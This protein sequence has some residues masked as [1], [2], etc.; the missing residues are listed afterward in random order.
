MGLGLAVGNPP[1]IAAAETSDTGPAPV[2][3]D[4]ETT[5]TPTGDSDDTNPPSA[6]DSDDTTASSSRSSTTERRRPFSIVRSSGGARTAVRTNPNKPSPPIDDDSSSAVRSSGGGNT[7]IRDWRRDLLT[8]I[9]FRGDSDDV[10]TEAPKPP[11]GGSRG[12]TT[13]AATPK[14]LSPKKRK[15]VEDTTI[16]TVISPRIDVSAGSNTV[17]TDAA[18]RSATP[19]GPIPTTRT[20][21]NTTTSHVAPATPRISAASATPMRASVRAVAGVLGLVGVAPSATG[22]SVPPPEHPGLWALLAWTR[23][24]F[25]RT[26]RPSAI[27]APPVPTLVSQTVDLTRPPVDLKAAELQAVQAVSASP[28]QQPGPL[29]WLRDQIAQTLFNQPPTVTVDSTQTS[30]DL[31]GVTTGLLQATDPEGDP[32]TYTVTRQPDNGT[33]VV[34]AD[35]TF[36]YTPDAGFAGPD[37]FTVRATDDTGSVVHR[38]LRAVFPGLHSDS[39][40]VQVVAATADTIDVGGQP[41]GVV[42][43]PDGT[44]TY[45]AG[46]GND[47]VVVID[48]ATN[49]VI[50]RV[51]VGDG[52]APRG[53]AV[54]PDGT[55]VYVANLGTSH[56]SII[57]TDTNTVIDTIDVGDPASAIALSPNGDRV[58]VTE[59]AGS[60]AGTLTVIDTGTKDTIASVPVGDEPSDV[61]VSPSGDQVYVT[62][63]FSDSVSLY[64]PG[65]T[66]VI[67]IDAGKS[68]IGIALSDDGRR[69]YIVNDYDNTV[70][71][72]D[73]TDSHTVTTIDV[74][75]EPFGIA[76]NGDR[77]YVTNASGN[78]VTVIDTSTNSVVSTIAVDG[79][80]PLDLALSPDGSR[81]YVTNYDSGTVS[82][83]TLASATS[84]PASPRLGLGTVF[85]W[86]GNQVSQTL[87]NQSPTA[88][89]DSADLV[90]NTDGTI[91]GLVAATDPENDTVTYVV[92]Q[93]PEH[94]T[95]DLNS[96][97]TFTYTPNDGYFGPDSFQ[98]RAADSGSLIHG[99]LRLVNPNFHTDT[100]TVSLTSH[101]VST[102]DVGGQPAAVVVAPDGMHTY[103]SAPAQGGNAIKVIDNQTNTV[104]ATIA[105]GDTNPGAI[106]ITPD[107]TQ[108]YVPDQDGTTVT[109]ID[110]STNTVK[111]TITLPDAEG[112]LADVAISPDG[113]QAYVS[114]AGERGTV[115]FI[116]TETNAVTDTVF[117]DSYPYPLNLTAGDGRLYFISDGDSLVVMDTDTK[118]ILG[119]VPVSVSP[120]GTAITADGDLVYV[121]SNDSLDGRIQVIDTS[122]RTVVRQAALKTLPSAVALSDD[123][124]A[125]FVTD[126]EKNTVSVIDTGTLQVLSTVAVGD[127]PVAVAFGSNGRVYVA[128]E[129]S[130]TVSVITLP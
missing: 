111:D 97:G 35:G 3:T 54:S 63:R 116:D 122:D 5:D 20:T 80:Q 2:K 95:V 108:V 69:A 59:R 65:S 92:T 99:L 75:D 47:Q 78:S 37:T 36:T 50:A 86:I 13:T 76:V 87:F 90:Q 1:G 24:E 79:Q 82:V 124:V 101:E 23:R 19:P 72:L 29:A 115:W 12:R 4:S 67:T 89:Y 128:N 96:D 64:V 85:G 48:N 39:T 100:V 74:G 18:S 8:R 11:T 121:V 73:T 9:D 7:S 30:Q 42:V 45:V 109:V 41:Y 55:R 126:V 66:E 14:T 34:N 10:S 52:S 113:K 77:A 68:P 91:T 102:I 110:T 120:K 51:E 44:R 31:T 32:L 104:V 33:V 127:V 88:T 56:V 26:V 84:T 21:I 114:Q 119:S 130:G 105:L 22:D 61:V 49:Q 94:G 117:L 70:T 62:N 81:A 107:G 15:P 16:S 71:V 58:Y 57:D 38:L 46:G 40:D 118:D 129:E 112:A 27:T 98:V 17:H 103:V 60:G 6:S 25:E 28:T 43:S 83:L 123:G 53:V 106:A 125:A 93:A